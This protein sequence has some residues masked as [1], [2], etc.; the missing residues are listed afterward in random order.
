MPYFYEIPCRWYNVD[1]GRATEFYELNR[2]LY[3]TPDALY[4]SPDTLQRLPAHSPQAQPQTTAQ[5]KVYII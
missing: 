1:C 2:D 5:L 4:I 3:I